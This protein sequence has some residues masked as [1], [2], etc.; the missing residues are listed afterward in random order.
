M[1]TH[2]LMFRGRIFIHCFGEFT[3]DILSQFLIYV[4]RD[5]CPQ[6]VNKVGMVRLVDLIL[7][8]YVK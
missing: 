2:F 1:E 6:I 7:S 5:R 4:Q 8:K 3:F